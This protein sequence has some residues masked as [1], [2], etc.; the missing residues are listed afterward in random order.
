MIAL[1]KKTVD[2]SQTT[3][4][5]SLSPSTFKRI[6]DTEKRTIKKIKKISK[7]EKTLNSIKSAKLSNKRIIRKMAKTQTI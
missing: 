5:L 1:E 3:N 6:L 7:N 4:D 2:P